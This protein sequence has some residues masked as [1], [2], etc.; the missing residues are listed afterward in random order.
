MAQPLVSIVVPFYNHRHLIKRAAENLFKQSYRN[1][2][3]ILVD[4]NSSDGSGE[5][6][7]A[8]AKEYP[9]KIRYAYQGI[10]G[11]PYAYNKGLAEAR[12]EYICFL[13]VDDEFPPTKLAN[14]VPI[15]EG[16]PEAGMVYGLTR[17]IYVRDGRNIIQDAGIAHEGVN[18]PP[19]L[20]I[21][22]INCL[23]HL[24]QNGA[25]L[26]RTSIARGIGGFPQN[27]LMGNDDAAF[28]IKL[29]LNYKVWFLP[30]EAIY[31]YRHPQSEGARLNREQSVTLRY[32]DT[33]ASWVV[34]YTFEY[35]KRTGD[36]RPRYWAERSLAGNLAE[37][38]YQASNSR[39]QRQG[40]LSNMLREQR[41]KGYLLGTQYGVLF[42][43]YR[44]LPRRYAKLASRIFY[45]MLFLISPKKFPI[46]IPLPG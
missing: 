7:Q 13:D 22:W 31:Y 39:T 32:I 16:H 17:R 34:P 41:D 21:D 40:I 6:A 27:L 15:L 44:W 4:N 19:Y 8:L 33:Y 29:A 2:E 9:E 25:A 28:L 43:F 3:L 18:E 5:V 24:P 30:K 11:I 35:E 36:N 45:R 38:A 14:Q 42:G 1:W 10:R 12:G 23:Y 46:D 37:Y 26:V 20:G